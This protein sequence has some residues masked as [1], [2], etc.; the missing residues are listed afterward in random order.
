MLPRTISASPW[1][2]SDPPLNLQSEREPLTH[3]LRP[4]LLMRDLLQAMV[5]HPLDFALETSHTVLLALGRET[6]VL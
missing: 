3:S 5:H 4:S 1:V 2:T 6:F